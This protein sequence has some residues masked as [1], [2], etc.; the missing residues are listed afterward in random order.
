M[1]VRLDFHRG[2]TSGGDVRPNYVLYFAVFETVD[3]WRRG[4]SNVV[5]PCFLSR[6]K[7]FAVLYSILGILLSW[8]V[9]V[10]S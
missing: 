3:I 1:W 5:K 8:Y 10:D 6:N 7:A 9:I 4:Y 2:W